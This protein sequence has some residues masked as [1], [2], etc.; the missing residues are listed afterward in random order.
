MRVTA[1][2]RHRSGENPRTARVRQIMLDTTARGG[3]EPERTVTPIDDAHSEHAL[4]ASLLHPNWGDWRRG[5]IR[6][7]LLFGAALLTKLGEDHMRERMGGLESS[8]GQSLR[9]S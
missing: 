2:Q 5:R 6:G 1:G 7:P 4:K 8:R 3:V 9:R